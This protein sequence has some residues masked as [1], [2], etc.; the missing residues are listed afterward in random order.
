[1]RNCNHRNLCYVSEL[2]LMTIRKG[3]PAKGRKLVRRHLTGPKV[4]LGARGLSAIELV[5]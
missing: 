2:G 1:M 5:E 3:F 4:P